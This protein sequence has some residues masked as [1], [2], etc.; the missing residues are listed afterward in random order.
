[1]RRSG[2]NVDFV[3]APALCF[4]GAL[5]ML[6]LP[7]AWV[8]AWVLAAVFHELC[9]IIAVRICGYHIFCVKISFGG[10]LIEAEPMPWCAELLSTV[11]GPLGGAALVLFARW[12]PRVALCACV[13]TLYNLLPVYPLDGGRVLR[14]IVRC[15]ASERNRQR[16]EAVIGG[17]TLSFVALFG[18][19][20]TFCLHLG[21]IPVACAALFLLRN[22]KFPCK[23]TQLRV[24]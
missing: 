5:S 21:P 3:F 24:Q 11:A 18:V 8:A 4:L 15:C 9:H 20:A 23:Q 6:L 2:V 22:I 17:V 1:M 7:L 10:A 13:Q 14:C 19:Y 16:I 12:M